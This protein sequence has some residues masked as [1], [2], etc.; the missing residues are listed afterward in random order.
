[1]T[2]KPKPFE[3][4]ETRVASLVTPLN[5][6]SVES[7][8]QAPYVLAI[9]ANLIR[10]NFYSSK[11]ILA[12]AVSAVLQNSASSRVRQLDPHAVINSCFT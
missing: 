1:M 10:L 2:Y 8:R 11:A 6:S 3:E 7:K 12:H 5:L 9:A 4:I